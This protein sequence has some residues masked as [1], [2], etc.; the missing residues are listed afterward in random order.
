MTPETIYGATGLGLFAIGLYHALVLPSALRRIVALNVASVGAGFVLVIAAWRPG[1]AADPV[2][3]ALVI[4]GIVVLVAATAVAL[5][6]VRALHDSDTTET[7][8]TP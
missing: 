2:P 6:L 3:H 4:T 1:A 5:A 7:D 8:D